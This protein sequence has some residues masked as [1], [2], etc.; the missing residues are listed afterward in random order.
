MELLTLVPY[1][2]R[3]TRI[4]TYEND[5]QKKQFFE[6]TDLMKLVLTRPGARQ[7]T[8]MF[9]GAKSCARALVMPKSVVLLT[10]YAPNICKIQISCALIKFFLVKHEVMHSTGFGLNPSIDETNTML[11]PPRCLI[12]GRASFASNKEALTLFS[13]ILS[14]ASSLAS[15]SSSTGVL[16]AA[17][18]TSMSRPPSRT[19]SV[20]RA[21]R[22]SG[23]PTLQRILKTLFK[24]SA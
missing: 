17:L 8:R 14:H 10:E 13:K 20:S 11:P 15:R 19:V 22:S 24:P 4:S 7:L 23:L 2:I 9:S 3:P 18:Q 6:L 12:K 21:C 1:Q 16:T 5:S